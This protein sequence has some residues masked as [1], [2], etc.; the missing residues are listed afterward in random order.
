MNGADGLVLTLLFGADTQFRYLNK[1]KP[2]F[3]PLAI[4]IEAGRWSRTCYMSGRLVSSALLTRFVRQQHNVISCVSE[5]EK[6]ILKSYLRRY[7][8]LLIS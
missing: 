5:P 8:L 3:F 1:I 6:K 2:C 7:V 4:E